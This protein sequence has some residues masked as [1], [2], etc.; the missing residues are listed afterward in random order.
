MA[1]TIRI[2]CKYTTPEGLEWAGKLNSSFH[3]PHALIDG[4]ETSLKWGTPTEIQI[5]SGARHRLEVYF[6]VFDVLRMCSAEAEVEPIPDGQTRVCQYTVELTD[7]Y[8]K[9]GTLSVAK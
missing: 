1:A 6:R 7:R 8:L 5:A 2:T 9:R 4:K 3:P